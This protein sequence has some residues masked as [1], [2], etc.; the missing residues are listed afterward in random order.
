VEDSAAGGIREG[1]EDGI[2]PCGVRLNHVVE[3]IAESK[4]CQPFG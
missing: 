1:M 2:E 4:D 3:C